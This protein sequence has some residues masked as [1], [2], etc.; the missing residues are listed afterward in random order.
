MKEIE[1][2]PEQQAMAD[3]IED[4]VGAK[5]RVELKN[6]ARLLASKENHELF[7][8]T[9]FQL[10]DM[11]LNLGAQSLDAALEAR[12]KKPTKGPA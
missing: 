7:G 8:E 6:I 11:L 1:L 3:E 5:M 4:V 2:T 12:K 9:E 10:R